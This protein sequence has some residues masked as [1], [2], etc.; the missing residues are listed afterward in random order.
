SP[1]HD[2]AVV[3]KGN[4]I[5]A[6]GCF[7]PISFRPDIEKTLGTRHRAGLAITEE[8]DAIVLIVSPVETGLPPL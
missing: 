3:I 4:K 8:A 7:L 2:G 6:A 5:V 1:I